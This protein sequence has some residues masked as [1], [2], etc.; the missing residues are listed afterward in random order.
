MMTTPDRGK[1]FLWLVGLAVRRPTT[2]RRAV[3]LAIDLDL[4]A[5]DQALPE[6]LACAERDSLSFVAFALP[7]CEPSR[8]AT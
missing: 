8:R 2:L 7:C 4:T 1:G 3:D 6:I 5:L